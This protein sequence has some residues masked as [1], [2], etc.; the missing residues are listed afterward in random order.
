[1]SDIGIGII[2]ILES[3]NKQHLINTYRDSRIQAYN[4]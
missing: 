4:N 3:K 2:G 1:M